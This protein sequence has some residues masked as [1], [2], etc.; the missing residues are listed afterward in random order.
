MLVSILPLLVFPFAASSEA[1]PVLGIHP[2]HGG[3]PAPAM[4]PPLEPPSYYSSA[5]PTP[6]SVPNHDDSQ[7]KPLDQQPVAPLPSPPGNLA[8]Y[9]SADDSSLAELCADESIDTVILGYVHG[10]E[11]TNG[12]PIVDFGAACTAKHA[13]DDRHASG[14]ASCPE[15]GQQVQTC[16]TR[17]KKVFLSIGG[18]PRSNSTLSFVDPADARRAAVMLWSLFGQGNPHGPDMRPLGEAAVDGFDFAWTSAAASSSSVQAFADTVRTLSDMPADGNDE[19]LLRDVID[20]AFATADAGD[21]SVCNVSSMKQSRF[22]TEGGLES[23][24]VGCASP[25]RTRLAERGA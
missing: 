1:S 12:F 17:G 22:C 19:E 13:D 23:R 15:L 6:S 16:Q 18:G 25:Y 11:A 7:Q 3:A 10:F 2:G 8:I 9:Y 5:L 14:L 4:P 24:T 20:I 21:D